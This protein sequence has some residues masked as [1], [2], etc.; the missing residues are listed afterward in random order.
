MRQINNLAL[1]SNSQQSMY[2]SNSTTNI[3]AGDDMAQINALVGGEAES[4]LSDF[5][6]DPSAAEP[7][8]DEL[9]DWIEDIIGGPSDPTFND[10]AAYQ[11]PVGGALFVEG[12]NDGNSVHPNDVDQGRLGDCYLIAALGALAHKNPEA[13]KDMIKDNGDGT[14]TVTFYDTNPDR[15]RFPFSTGG[16][17]DFNTT[18][19]LVPVEVT[20]DADVPMKDGHPIYAGFGDS[21]TEMWV[22]LIE[23]AYAKHFGNDSYEGI[24]GGRPGRAMEHITGS[25]SLKQSLV[26]VKADPLNPWG[27]ASNWDSII[28]GWHEFGI[29][30]L[31]RWDDKG[32]ALTASTYD[33][34]NES[35]PLFDNGDLS[36]DHAYYITDVN[37]ADNTVTL[38]NPWGWQNSGITL[39][40][41]EFQAHFSRVE[42]NT[43]TAPAFSWGEILD[44]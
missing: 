43:A 5:F 39:S 4:A 20:V 9:F 34:K 44:D 37:Q 38:Q 31:A 19:E 22:M 10:P 17:M 7:A 30:D 14:Y 12:T 16:F 28:P 36:T 35:R 11:F 26:T 25:P 41:E 24:E 2:N 8:K 29:D 3:V 32:Y 18:P 40:Y 15:Y 21:G 27:S 23:K 1:P 33:D 13:I 42:A 6:N